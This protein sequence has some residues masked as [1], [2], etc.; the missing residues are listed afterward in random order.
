M[1]KPCLKINLALRAGVLMC[2]FFG[3]LFTLQIPIL[4]DGNTFLQTAIRLKSGELNS[5][6]APIPGSGPYTYLPYASIFFMPL[7]WMAAKLN[8]LAALS[9]ASL[10]YLLNT[11]ISEYLIKPTRSRMIALVII[12]I[13]FS[14]IVGE[15]IYIGQIDLILLAL[16]TKAFVKETNITLSCVLFSIVTVFKP[17]FF[18]F[19][20]LYINKKQFFNPLICS[21]LVHSSLAVIFFFFLDF[22]ILAIKNL[23]IQFSQQASS[24][25]STLDVTNQS[26]V[27]V[28]K[29]LWTGNQFQS[30]YFPNLFIGKM[31]I[32]QN[33]YLSVWV[34]SFF[35]ITLGMAAHKIAKNF[36]GFRQGTFVFPVALSAL[37][38]ISPLFWQV[39][40]VYLIPIAIITAP[41][42]LKVDFQKGIT[43]AWLALIICTNPI[44][45]GSEVADFFLA[46][47]ATCLFAIVC[48]YKI[49]NTKD[50][51]AGQGKISKD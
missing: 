4:F 13:V 20:L 26:L 39:H 28:L 49:P 7:A 5:L 16:L 3:I 2:L 42:N 48:I 50:F 6:Y 9:T 44:L 37:P 27:A 14:S 43:W 19:Y 17:Q 51:F 10:F 23:F 1:L 29:R 36:M 25:S 34:T 22:N 33:L 45:V 38:I 18:I 24:I 46:I 21:F 47:G 8:F 41:D 35:A 15:S 11:I 12:A 30:R 32:F 31:M 40:A